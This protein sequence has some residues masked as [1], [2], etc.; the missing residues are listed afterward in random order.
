MAF[1]SHF[2]TNEK[3]SMNTFKDDN[4]F[5]FVFLVI[6]FDILL[7]I[8]TADVSKLWILY[9]VGHGDTA[10]TFFTK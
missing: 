1:P 2:Y 9:D 10:C 8:F 6:Y 7:L 4:I 5:A 3:L